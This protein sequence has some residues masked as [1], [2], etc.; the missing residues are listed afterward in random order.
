MQPPSRRPKPG[1]IR[2]L[3]VAG[4][5][6]S[7]ST[8]VSNLLGS[9]PGIVSLGELRYLWER[10]LHERSR[11][12]CGLPVPECP[13]WRDV[14]ERAYPTAPADVAAVKR[15]DRQLLRLRSFGQLRRTA[16]A[17]LQSDPTAAA[18]GEELATVYRAIHHQTGGAVIV[19][20][21]NLPGYG[22][23]L[24]QIPDIELTVL[25]LVRDP[26][27]VAHSW[28]RTR[29]REDRG[30]GDARMGQEGIVKSALLWDVWNRVTERIW[31]ADPQRYVRVRYEDVVADPQA[32][33]D[34]VMR[35]LGRSGAELPAPHDGQIE[36]QVCHTVAGNPMRAVAGQLPLTADDE[37]IRSMPWPRRA[38]V[39]LMTERILVRYGYPRRAPHPAAPPPATTGR[40]FVEDMRGVA[41]LRARV[42]RNLQWI[43]DEGLSRVLE[44]KEIDPLRNATASI[45]KWRYRRAAASTRGA[46]V[47][48]FVVGLQRSGTNM[49]VRGLAA[50]PETEVHNENDPKAFERFK[51]RPLPVIQSIV[52][53]SRHS[54][55]IFKP[56]C[57]SHRTAEL[58]EQVSSGGKPLAVWA[59]RDVE[60]RVRSALAK[61]GDGNLQVLREF[62]DGTN[63]TRWH[64]QGMSNDTADFV[65]SFDYDKLSPASGA[66]LMWLVRNQLYFDLGLD[67]RPDTF[68]VSYND[69]LANP[70]QTM[71]ALCDFLGFPYRS[72]LVKHVTPRSSSYR[73][74]LD[75]DARVAERCAALARRLDAA[76]RRSSA[77]TR[78]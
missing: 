59:Y 70:T 62:A 72:G 69:F 50:A 68:L 36:L 56:L 44:E 66:A 57:D 9:A 5:G 64:V 43:R 10:G 74:P 51:L 6:R 38:L 58:L 53:N 7:G 23:L 78:R 48:V 63:V 12:G 41:R 75:I 35:I 73:E 60:G 3:F 47:P 16:R 15:A 17:G 65:R 19:D 14:I 30:T 2:V 26:R 29:I 39:T 40:V 76:A 46:A 42:S 33:L 11:C 4:T 1:R 61:F 37:W 13:F 25:H 24:D 27:G 22:L 45:G 21:S 49:L 54:H 67:E 34:P 18:Y 32:A 28:S 31:G 55:V 52:A 77:P 8:L 71:Q 20:S